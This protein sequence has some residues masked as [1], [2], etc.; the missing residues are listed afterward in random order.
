MIMTREPSI[1]EIEWQAQ[2]CGMHAAHDDDAG[3]AQACMTDDRTVRYRAVA[4]ALRSAPCSRPPAD[5][6]GSIARLAIARSD[7]GLER[8]LSRILAVVFALSSLVAVALYGGRWW[9]AVHQAF[10]G[11]ALA[12]LLTGMGCLVVSWMFGELRSIRSHRDLEAAR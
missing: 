4:Q 3:M 5:F 12:W 8:A 2:E 7:A 1:D 9:Q 11:D 6:A 10:G